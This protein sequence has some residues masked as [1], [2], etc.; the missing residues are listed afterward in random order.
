MSNI[1]SMRWTILTSLIVGFLLAFLTP[2]HLIDTLFPIVRMEA[3]VVQKTTTDILVNLSGVKPWYSTY[4]SCRYQGIEA[5]NDSYPRRRDLNMQRVDKPEEKTTRPPGAYE[6]G[7]W[8]IWPTD[9]T[10]RIA[11]DVEYDCSGRVVFVR[12][13]EVSL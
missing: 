10:K 6:F 7:V 13:A 1:R 5:Y 9:N 3:V 4:R 2:T 8:R 12:A 11:I